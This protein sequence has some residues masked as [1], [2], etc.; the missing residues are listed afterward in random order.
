M[1]PDNEQRICAVR[2]PGTSRARFADARDV[3]LTLGDWVVVETFAGEEGAQVV[4]APDQWLSPVERDDAIPI[5]RRLG[6][7]ELTRLAELADQ[8]RAWID[9]A[10]EALRQH[11]P[12]TYLSGLRFTLDGATAVVSVIGHLPEQREPIADALASAL[13][14]SVLLEQE[15]S[16]SPERALLGGGTGR[17]GIP[18]AETFRELLER[19]FDVLRDRDAFAPQGLPRLGTEVATPQGPGQLV[20]V[21]IRHW[22]AT[23]ALNGGEEITVSVDE[24]REPG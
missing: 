7:E 5:L 1:S 18:K 11:T 15:H 12:E 8:S 17:I 10:A 19:R 21:D 6:D 23:V 2:L 9:T 24:L 22:K 14:L 13:G 4:V 16:G 3:E 20:A